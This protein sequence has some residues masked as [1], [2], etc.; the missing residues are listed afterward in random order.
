MYRKMW[1]LGF[2]HYTQSCSGDGDYAKG[3]RIMWAQEGYL[4]D[5][6]IQIQDATQLPVDI[7]RIIFEDYSPYPQKVTETELDRWD[8]MRHI[9]RTS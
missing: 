4:K 1:R 3:A 7:V 8:H 9:E 6:L 2:R 5:G